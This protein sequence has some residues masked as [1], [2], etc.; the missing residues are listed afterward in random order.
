MKIDSYSYL[1]GASGYSEC[2]VIEKFTSPKASLGVL[3]LPLTVPLFV[4]N[5]MILGSRDLLARNYWP[6][7]LEKSSFIIV[8]V[9][10]HA[11]GG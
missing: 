11:C 9:K 10:F 8:V 5:K 1:G 4:Q 2:Q 6:L 7:I 3:L